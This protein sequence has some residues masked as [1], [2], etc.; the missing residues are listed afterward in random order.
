M[1]KNPHNLETVEQE[2]RCVFEA[3][4]STTSHGLTYLNAIIEEVFHIYAQAPGN[5]APRTNVPM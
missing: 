4:M 2:V 5:F 1:L 3:I